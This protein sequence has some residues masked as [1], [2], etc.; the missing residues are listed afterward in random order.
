MR[1]LKRLYEAINEQKIFDNFDE[2]TECPVVCSRKQNI[3]WLL[4]EEA[5]RLKEFMKVTK[6]G[7]AYFFEGGLC[8]LLKDKHCSIYSDRPLECRLNPL[9]IYEIEGD[10]YWIV[11]LEC[12]IMK[13][14]GKE[15]IEKLKMGIK[16]ISPFITRSMKGEFRKISKAIKSFDPLVEGRDFIRIAKL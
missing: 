4:P 12:P 2:C 6:I 3:H 10:L 16:S 5:G 1:T 11:Y 7:D 8:P 9:S 14:R 13:K 15:F